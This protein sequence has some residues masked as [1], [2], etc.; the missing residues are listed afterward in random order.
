MCLLYATMLLSSL[1]DQG[2]RSM[3]SRFA[4]DTLCAHTHIHTYGFSMCGNNNNNWNQLTI[5]L[6]LQNNINSILLVSN[7][8]LSVDISDTLHVFNICLLLDSLKM[9]LS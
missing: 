1:R 9:S 3:G 8:L 4:K 5:K 6:M 2:E 7:V